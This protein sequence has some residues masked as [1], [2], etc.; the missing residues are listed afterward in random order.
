MDSSENRHGRISI[1]S[2]GKYG[3][4]FNKGVDLDVLEEQM[5]TCGAVS[6]GAR[7]V[8]ELDQDEVI[9]DGGWGLRHIFGLLSFSAFT[10]SYMNRNNIS[11]AIVAMVASNASDVTDQTDVCPPRSSSNESSSIP[12]AD[13]QLIRFSGNANVSRW[14][15]LPILIVTGTPS[16]RQ[17]QEFDW[18]EET[19]GM[20]LGCFF[21]GYMVGNLLGG[22]ASEYLGGRVTLGISVLSV[23][24]V[25]LL[26]PVCVRTSTALY[27]GLRIVSGIFQGPLFPSIFTLMAAWIPPKDKASFSSIVFVGPQLGTVISMALGGVMSGSDFLGGWPS[28]FYVFGAVGVLWSVAWFI[29]IRDQPEKHPWISSKELSY[30][31]SNSPTVKSSKNGILSALPHVSVYL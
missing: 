14:N 22:F 3:A 5:N 8:G 18:D 9:S 11:I 4:H 6:S 2:D 30:I 24:I 29:L 15:R 10:V 7:A 13:K 23:S 19:Q 25:S 27:V 16:L 20:I 26:S 28:V 21:Y 31:R 12:R 1:I 17:S